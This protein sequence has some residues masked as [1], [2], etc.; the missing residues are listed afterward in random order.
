MKSPLFEESTNPLDAE[1]WRVKRML[2]IFRP[3]ISLTIES[4]GDP[5]TTTTNCVE[6]ADRAKHCLN[7]LKE[8]RQRWKFLINCSLPLCLL[9]F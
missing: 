9:F 1:E 6:R 7:Q 4:V 8:K 5:P 2:K 3:D